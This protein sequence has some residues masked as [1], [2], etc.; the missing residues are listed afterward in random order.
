M[1]CDPAY[2]I[3]ISLCNMFL[4]SGNAGRSILIDASYVLL[5]DRMLN[6]SQTI[7]RPSHMPYVKYMR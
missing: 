5:Q 6:L 1:V 2:R 3:F 7:K 4:M